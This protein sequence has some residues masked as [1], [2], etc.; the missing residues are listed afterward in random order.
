MV[1]NG[2][3]KGE[4]CLIKEN[5][6]LS[7]DE[8]TA[9]FWKKYEADLAECQ[10]TKVVHMGDV[11]FFVEIYVKNPQLIIFGG[12]HVSQPVAKIGKMLGFHVTVMDDRED[13]VTSERFPD[14]DRLIKG[15]YD[16]LSDKIPAYENAYYVIVQEVISETVPVPDRF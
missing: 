1:L 13:F 2:N 7:S 11:D 8:N 10:E 14:A 15:S 6:C 5:H 9:D 3:H 4:K 12:G 16:E